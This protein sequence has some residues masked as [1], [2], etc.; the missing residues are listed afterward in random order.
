[1]AHEANDLLKAPATAHRRRDFIARSQ[2]IL[3]VFAVLAALGFWAAEWLGRR[4]ARYSP[5]PMAS[6]HSQWDANCA[7]CHESS[8]PL[9]AGNW[10]A[11]ASGQTHVADGA[12]QKCHDGPTHHSVQIDSEVAGCTSCHRE[13]QGRAGRLLAVADSQC[14]SCHQNL[15]G[16]S[17]LIV[18]QT[19]QLFGNVTRFAEG[20]HPDF[21]WV[22]GKESDPG[23]VAFNHALHMSPG[24]ILGGKSANAKGFTLNQIDEPLRKNYSRD[25]ATNNSLVQLEC[26]S[27]HRTEARDFPTQEGQLAGVPLNPLRPAQGTGRI[28]APIVYEQHCQACHPLTIDRTLPGNPKSDLFAVRH[29]MQPKEI[30]EELQGRYTNLWLKGLWTPT[31]AAGTPVLPGKLPMPK[32]VADLAESEALAAVKKLL[33]DEPPLKQRVLGP[34]TCQK[35][36]ESLS[37]DLGVHQTVPRA[38][39]PVVWFE[40]ARF[41]HTAHR[42]VD[43]RGCHEAAYPD[44]ASFSTR[45]SS[46]ML[47]TIKNCVQ[48][49][50]PASGT[51]GGAR[52]DCIACHSYHHGDAPLEGRGSQARGPRGGAKSIEHFQHGR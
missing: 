41:D 22:D 51:T 2:V 33:I 1:M 39:I 32:K 44:S 23:T 25:G 28:M 37:P 19:V 5:G 42:A 40:H 7:A 17:S 35:C 20:G 24:M 26:R 29:R 31:P 45:S 36:H 12:C 8:Q 13:H 6:V 34:T 4:E 30:I 47:P 43:C 18:K 27:C 50:A 10:F 15:A 9:A 11:V 46:V 3:A 49:H 16:H 21:R 14:T 52:F 48:C 38:N